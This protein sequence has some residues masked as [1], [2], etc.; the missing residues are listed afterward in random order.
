MDSDTR[1][2]RKRGFFLSPAIP[3][4]NDTHGAER[5]ARIEDISLR[6]TRSDAGGGLRQN[7]GSAPV[8][9]SR[10][11]ASPDPIDLLL[12]LWASVQT[13]CASPLREI[14]SFLLYSRARSLGAPVKPLLSVTHVSMVIS[15]DARK[16]GACG[17]GR[18][19]P[20]AGPAPCACRA[21]ASPPRLSPPPSP[22]SR[23][24]RGRTSNDRSYAG[25]RR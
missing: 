2:A 23:A 6:L 9:L 22:V 11:G 19:S 3:G 10:K 14:S 20:Q 8:P 7:G 17:A 25:S 13:T 15:D 21:R 1:S 16:A 24:A 5:K 18:K 4:G 12:L